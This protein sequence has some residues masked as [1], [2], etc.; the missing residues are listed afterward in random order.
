M[1]H[2][3]HLTLLALSYLHLL[4]LAFFYYH[5]G[6]TGPEEDGR[7]ELF[8]GARMLGIRSVGSEDLSKFCARHHVWQVMREEVLEPL[9]A[10]VTTV[11]RDEVAASPVGE[12]LGEILSVSVSYDT[13]LT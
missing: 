3:I 7:G 11:G 1:T 8:P 10:A 6:L 12:A 5:T 9:I 2:L 4:L 13:E